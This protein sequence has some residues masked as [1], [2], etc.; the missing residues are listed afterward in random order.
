MR[1]YAF[2]PQLVAILPLFAN[3]IA[4]TSDLAAC[5]YVAVSARFQFQYLTL[6]LFLFGDR[7]VRPHREW[8]RQV[9]DGVSDDEAAYSQE[10][11]DALAYSYVIS[12]GYEGALAMLAGFVAN[13]DRHSVGH[14]NAMVLLCRRI[15][16]A[17]DD[18]AAT[19]TRILDRMISSPHNGALHNSVVNVLSRPN[20]ID[21]HIGGR[22]QGRRVQLGLSRTTLAADLALTTEALTAIEDGT[23]R[24]DATGLDRAGARLSVPATYFFQAM[25]QTGDAID[26]Q[27][28]LKN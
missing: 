21:R 23:K 18:E 15:L 9:S 13:H 10:E 5:R 7:C 3:L 24:L 22:L 1:I 2:L 11:I 12:D 16:D 6:H 26:T 28:Q 8:E 14:K 19:I 27:R 25:H 4:G 17:I 20:P